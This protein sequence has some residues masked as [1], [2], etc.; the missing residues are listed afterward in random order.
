MSNGG[1]ITRNMPTPYMK[2]QEKEGISSIGGY[3]IEDLNTVPVKPWPRMGGKGV[4]INLI[5]S[6]QANDGY[7]CEIPPGKA[8]EPQRHLFEETMVILKGRG[9][10]TLWQEGGRKQTFEWG[11]GSMFSPPLNCWYQLF[12]GQGDKPVRFL[13][14]TTAP[15]IINLF[16][17]SD[18]VFKNDYIFNDRYSG[19]EDYFSAKGKIHFARLWESNFISDVYTLKLLEYK[20]RGAGGI[21]LRF[22]MSE[23]SFGAHISEFPVGTYKKGHRHGPGAHVIILNGTGYSLMWPEGKEPQKFPWKK[24]S[25]LVPPDKWFHQHFNTG[26]E[27]ARYL[28][29]RWGN[30]KYGI[31]A[32]RMT[33]DYKSAESTD[34]GGDQ[35]EYPNESP[36][37]MKL[38]REELAKS[39]LGPKMPVESW[40]R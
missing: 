35:I 9:A 27:P 17:N 30:D 5:G 21:N 11:E 4:F 32:I 33:H 18:F 3:A 38:F 10:T 26:K 13:S 39:S 25:M 12:N 14:V 1:E 40:R 36:A 34:S 2:W 23:N 22:Q 19:E 37:I 8:L 28:A 29:L 15:L 24:G 16:H 7:I 6:E 20:E 31:W